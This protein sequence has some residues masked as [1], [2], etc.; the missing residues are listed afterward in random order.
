MTSKNISPELMYEGLLSDEKM[1]FFDQQSIG[2]A[3]WEGRSSCTL[4]FKRLQA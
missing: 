3:Y 1:I 4:Y 2:I